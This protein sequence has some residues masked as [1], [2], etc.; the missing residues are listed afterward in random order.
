MKNFQFDNFREETEDIIRRWNSKDDFV[1][2]TSGSTGTPKKIVHSYEVMKEVSEEVV[3]QNNYTKDSFILNN[4][5]PPTSI[6]FPV[7][8]VI[9]TLISG[10]Q[11]RIKKFD[12]KTFVDDMIS[13]PTHMFIL[14]AIFRVMSKTKKW[15]NANFSSID[16]IASGAD[17]IPEGFANEIT[18]KGAKR[19]K[20]DFGSTEVPPSITDSSHEK[21]VGLRL[22]SLVDHYFGDDGELFVKWKSQKDYWQSG[23][24]F[25]E[26]FEMIGR[27]KNILKMQGC[28]AVNPETVEKYILDNCDVTRALL[29]IKNEKP[30]LYYE[31]D[32]PESDVKE[33]LDQWYFSDNKVVNFVKRVDNIKVNHMNKLVRTQEFA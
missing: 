21:K 30:H 4:T 6:G 18:S 7:L 32:S 29:Q 22:S 20:M 12:T 11:A 15:K 14:P 27:K 31:G 19:F 3:R 33:V 17:L 28:S 25:T 2:F 10:C 5:L 9:P 23:D 16:T 26:D 8:T 13:G 24:L 1:Y